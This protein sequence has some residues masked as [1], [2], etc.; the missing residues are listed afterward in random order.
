[1]NVVSN[2]VT[3]KRGEPIRNENFVTVTIRLDKCFTGQKRKIL[4]VI[5]SVR[6]SGVSVMAE[7]ISSQISISFAEHLDFVRNSGCP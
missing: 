6:N 5:A 1:M 7:V 3:K 4:S 2:Y